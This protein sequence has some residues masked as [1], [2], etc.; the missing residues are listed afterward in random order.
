VH[1]DGIALDAEGAVWVANPEGQYAAL[2]VH[3]GGEILDPVEL[4]TL[5]YAVA[6][7]GPERRHLGWPPPYSNDESSARNSIAL[8][9][10]RQRSGN[11]KTP[12][13]DSPQEYL[14]DSGG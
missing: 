11:L 14:R 4:D 12:L 2:R 9:N 6:L 13:P 7:G 5:G 3:E 10:A 8:V 1:P